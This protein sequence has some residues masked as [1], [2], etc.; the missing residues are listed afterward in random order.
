ML[1]SDLI[2]AIY[3]AAEDG[4]WDRLVVCLSAALGADTAG[5]VIHS[6]KQGSA[7]I[8]THGWDPAT[9]S[10]YESHYATINPW[11]RNLPPEFATGEVI[12]GEECI[13][14]YRYL[15]TEFFQDFGRLNSMFEVAAT[16][17]KRD[18]TSVAYFAVHRGAGRPPFG[19][20]DFALLHELSPHFQRALQFRER[21]QQVEHLEAAL[22]L[23]DR[24]LL[25]VTPSLTVLQA[26]RAAV[27]LLARADGLSMGNRELRVSSP[28]D[29]SRLRQLLREMSALPDAARA[30]N[31]IAIRRPSGRGQYLVSAIRGPE[32]ATPEF[33]GS[34]KGILLLIVDTQASAGGVN[35]NRSLRDLFGLT[36]AEAGLVDA[37]IDSRNLVEAAALLQVSRNTA[38]AH[39]ASVYRKTSTHSVTE[40]LRLVLSIPPGPMPAP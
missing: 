26:T 7:E 19:R 35:R 6:F 1:D 27:I 28:K 20:E 8:V 33:L 38:K 39:L 36:Q 29:A 34:R 4:C 17:I 40:L 30:I 13:S 2:E 24:A 22:D 18:P 14:T 10:A 37:L 21:F 16:C 12:A 23:D 25:R 31:G 32:S 9:I 5:F 11:M 15:E 3:A